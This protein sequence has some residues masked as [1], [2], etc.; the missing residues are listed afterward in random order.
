MKYISLI[1]S[2]IGALLGI[3]ATSINHSIRKKDLN[4]LSKSLERQIEQDKAI[5]FY[6][7]ELKKIVDDLESKLDGTQIKAD[8]K[9]FN[10]LKLMNDRLSTIKNSSDFSMV[11]SNTTEKR[12]F[13]ILYTGIVVFFCYNLLF[14]K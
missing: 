12:I 5:D 13:Q 7:I 8:D 10:E 9:I 2:V 4:N 6:T 3:I 1:G 14:N 11:E